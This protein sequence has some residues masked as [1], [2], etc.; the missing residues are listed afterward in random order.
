MAV[1]RAATRGF[2]LFLVLVLLALFLWQTFMSVSK[3]LRFGI[4]VNLD[5][6]YPEAQVF[7]S[8][9]LCQLFKEGGGGGGGGG[10]GHGRGGT[11]FFDGTP[12]EVPYSP[13]FVQGY[14]HGRREG[15]VRKTDIDSDGDDN[16]WIAV[17]RLGFDQGKLSICY[18]YR[19][20]S[21]HSGGMDSLVS[22]KLLFLLD[23]LSLR[24]YLALPLCSSCS[25]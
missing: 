18:S 3:F 9:T 20:S 23:L 21:L 2:R 13:G 7:P 14:R 11:V 5:N 17:E 22:P 25:T 8:V 1:L 4:T 10:G 24:I 6:S 19:A 16:R 15:G 12:F